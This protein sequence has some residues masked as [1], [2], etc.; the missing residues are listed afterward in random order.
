MAGC[1]VKEILSNRRIITE[2]INRAIVNTEA[3]CSVG[4]TPA[5]SLPQT[6]L[7]TKQQWTVVPAFINARGIDPDDFG[8]TADPPQGSWNAAEGGRIFQGAGGITLRL[9]YITVNDFN[10]TVS[11]GL[12]DHDNPT[13]EPGDLAHFDTVTFREGGVGTPVVLSRTNPSTTTGPDSANGINY[14]AW[15]LV[16]AGAYNNFGTGSDP[17]STVAVA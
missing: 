5:P 13:T 1:D 2:G 7:G 3:R 12:C 16:I 6:F 15:N 8:E 4:S 10:N 9:L 14:R 17:N 11:V